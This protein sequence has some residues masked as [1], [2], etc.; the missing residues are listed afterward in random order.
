MSFRSLFLFFILSSGMLYAQDSTSVLVR[1]Q[2][3]LSPEQNFVGTF[4][5]NPAN[6]RYARRYS[7]SELSA[8]YSSASQQT[9]TQQLGN[10]IGQFLINAKSHYKMN[11]ENTV[12]G[13]AYYKNGKRK[14]VH[15][16]ESSDYQ[17]IYP[18][19]TADSIGGDLS[20]EEYSFSGGY[21]KAFSKMNLGISANYRALM[22]YRDTDPRPKNTVSDLKVSTG[23]SVNIGDH[24]VLGSALNLQ[25]YTQS[26]NLKFFSELGAP[27]VYHMV[28]LGVYNK[29]LTGNKLSSYYDGRGYGGSLQFFPKDRSGFGLS[30]GYN[31]FD[32]EKIMT[33]FQNLVASA[34]LENSY[35]AAVSYSKKSEEKFWGTKIGLFYTNRAGTENIFDN[36]S[37]TSYIKIAE[38]TKYTNQVTSVVFSGLYVI[39][40]PALT[41]SVAPSFNLKNTA[42][43]YSDPLRTVDIQQGIGRM[44]F[45]VSKLLS[46]S[47]I[48]LSASLEHNWILSSDRTLS[49]RK[50]NQIF[51][52]LDS[53]F[54][55]L[56]AGYSKVNLAARWDYTY[57][58]DLN[59][60]VKTSFDYYNY[61]KNVNNTFYQMSLG[62]TF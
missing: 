40:K 21:T 16:N 62:L 5:S 42:E 17:I 27:A 20:Y 13:N 22:E 55:Y 38:H 30:A 23:I 34:I 4:Y 19:V 3:D 37:T 18:Y 6:Q 56:S 49:D 41:W 29:L 53:N 44:D 2:E 12:F 28:G 32:Y 1:V 45:A 61:S 39:P 26:D 14:K 36:Q 8:D 9:N 31:R 10:G 54:A 57:K 33:E 51:D 50:T 11:P 15:W 47:L 35:E 7:L 25:K 60:F 48:N 52:L 58:P 46:P 24:Y 43:K 59:F